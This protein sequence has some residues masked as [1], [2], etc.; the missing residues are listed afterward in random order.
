[1]QLWW[2]GQLFYILT[3]IRIKISI[4]LSLW[5]V[6]VDRLHLTILYAVGGI[7]YYQPTNILH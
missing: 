1:M 4:S 6:T 5:R 7:T 2:L 3:T